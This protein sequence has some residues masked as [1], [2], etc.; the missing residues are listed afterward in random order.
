MFSNKMFELNTIARGT[1]ESGLGPVCSRGGA[2]DAQLKEDLSV[3]F[4]QVPSQHLQV[5]ASLNFVPLPG[6]WKV[7]YPSIF[8]F[9][10]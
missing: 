4:V 7:D 10:A 5:S 3:S 6:P 9:F 2:Q 8:G 1:K